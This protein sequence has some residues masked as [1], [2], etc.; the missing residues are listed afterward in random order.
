MVNSQEFKSCT[1]CEQQLAAEHFY[2]KGKSWDSSCKACVSEKK[3]NSYVSRK[4]PKKTNYK[5]IIIMP[6]KSEI[7]INVDDLIEAWEAFLIEEFA[8]G[9]TISI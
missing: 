2:K 1:K 4:S 7:N 9:Q 3:K 5:D 8:G 6:F